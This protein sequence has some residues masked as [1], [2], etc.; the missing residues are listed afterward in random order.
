[1]ECQYCKNKFSNKSNLLLHQRRAK[2]CLELRGLQDNKFSCTCSKVYTSKE[3]LY[4]HQKSCVVFNVKEVEEKKEDEKS[5]LLNIIEEQKEHIR[6]LEGRLE[7]IAIKSSTK[8]STTNNT[9]MINNYIANMQPIT[10]EHLRE[11]AE[12]LTLE[13]IKKGADGYAE[14]ALAFP[15]KDKIAC[16]DS[17]RYKFKF[18]NEE[19]N[20][21]TDIELRNLAEKFFKS[22]VNQNNTLTCAY[23]QQLFQH[24]N[25][26]NI[27]EIDRVISLEQQVRKSSE[28][29]K[30]DLQQNWVKSISAKT[31]SDYF[32]K[33]DNVTTTV[34]E[35]N[36]GSQTEQLPLE[37]QSLLHEG[38]HFV[39]PL[40]ENIN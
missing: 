15:F 10:E 28:G 20:V 12:N 7:N 3:N 17:S 19:G 36:Q 1:M 24:W 23:G 11:C 21:V 9:Q 30:T 38:V 33:L 35:V 26:S 2:Y 6:E 16:T 8:S 4:N 5:I 34:H 22:I 32:Q 39:D 29:E 13:H 37:D 14:Y 27:Q 18:K 40:H 25:R 31:V